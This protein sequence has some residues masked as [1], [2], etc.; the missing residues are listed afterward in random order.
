MSF[1]FFQNKEC[2]YFPCHKKVPLNQF[3]CIFCFCPLYNYHKCGG[4][5]KYIE[6]ILVDTKNII[7]RRD[8]SS[9]DLP[10]YKNQYDNIINAVRLKEN[11]KHN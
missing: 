6:D 7:Y 1:K 2:E 4:I 9:C 3:N 10:H 8:C 11:L 5:I